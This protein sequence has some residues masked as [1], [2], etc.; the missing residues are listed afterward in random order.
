MHYVIK[1]VTRV[2]VILENIVTYCRHSKSY[3]ICKMFFFFLF[4][5]TDLCDLNVVSEVYFNYSYQ[6][7]LTKQIIN[8]VK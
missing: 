1:Y 7:Y 4:S 6:I 5:F 2:K 3:K 8:V